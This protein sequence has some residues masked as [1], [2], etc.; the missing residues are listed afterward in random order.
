VKVLVVDD[1]APARRRLRRMLEEHVDGIESVEEAAGAGEALAA[2]DRQR[3]DLLL[4]DIEMPELDGLALVARHDGLPPVVFV[5]AHDTH[6]V[7]AFELDALDYL[8]KPVRPE[9]LIE[10]VRRARA[11]QPQR[12]PQ[13]Q[14]GDGEVPRVVTHQ[15]GTTR[16]FDA[17]TIT[18]FR[19]CDKYTLFAAEGEEH[20]TDEPLASL[21]RRLAP[22]GFVRAHRAELIR[23]TAVRSLSSADGIHEARLEDGQ[24]SRISR[25]LLGELKRQ[26]GL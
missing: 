14:L 6:A 10:A 21:G 19:A 3:P 13:L 22:W 24:V 15:R 26:L 18:R 9:R 16:L 4:L 23:L 5:T 12:R 17:R 20:L 8:M 2:I 1:E 7:K 11:R 25:R